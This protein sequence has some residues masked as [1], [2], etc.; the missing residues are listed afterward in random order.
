M[1][2]R[3]TAGSSITTL[4]NKHM[5]PQD[6]QLGAWPDSIRAGGKYNRR[7]IL[8]VLQKPLPLIKSSIK[9]SVRRGSF[10]MDPY[11][12]NR[13]I[14]EYAK[15]KYS[16]NH[17]A[18]VSAEQMRDVD[19]DSWDSY[20][21]FAFVRNP[22]T[23][24]VSDYHWRSAV[25]NSEGV[26]FKEFLMRLADPDLQDPENIRPPIITNWSIYTI[27]NEIALDYIGRY[28]ELNDDLLKIGRRLN[29]PMNISAVQAKSNVRPKNRSIREY[30]DE[31]C[32]ELVRMIY[33]KEITCFSYDVP[34]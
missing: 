12:L 7:A 9:Y 34:F 13:A 20:F 8:I 11:Y 5:G 30:Y 24:A 17:G 19:S 1:H 16:L 10:G 2:S 27:N 6:L 32:I 22:W 29:L 31:E 33:E 4:L 23:H 28:E 21:K 15:E 3:K 26:T 14:K 25:V 18:H